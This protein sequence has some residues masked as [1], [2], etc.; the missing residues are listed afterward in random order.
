MKR[1]ESS[2]IGCYVCSSVSRSD[3]NCEDPFNTSVNNNS[4]YID[5]CYGYRKDRTGV[6]PADHCIKVA[7]VSNWEKISAFCNTGQGDL[8]GVLIPNTLNKYLLC[9]LNPALTQET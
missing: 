7:G 6:F 4:Y 9:P 1:N 5:N 3:L 8:A 2:S